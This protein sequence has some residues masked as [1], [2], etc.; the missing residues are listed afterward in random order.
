MK[1][2]DKDV[3]KKGGDGKGSTLAN[4]PNSLDP[5]EEWNAPILNAA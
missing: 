5:Q 2:N 1:S 3:K 4:C